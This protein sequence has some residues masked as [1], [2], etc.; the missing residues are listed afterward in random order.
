MRS[1]PYTKVLCGFCLLL[2][3]GLVACGGPAQEE[4]Q[5]GLRDP[6]SASHTTEDGRSVYWELYTIGYAPGM[7]IDVPVR[8]GSAEA[9]WQ[10]RLCLFLLR[11]D[12]ENVLL[13]SRAFDVPAGAEFGWTM[14]ARIPEDLQPTT[15]ALSLVTADGRSR[16]VMRVAIGAPKVDT[17]VEYGPLPDCPYD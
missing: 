10:D 2:V 8:V 4:E 11:T 1:I 9:D 15:Y 6:V 7:E 16:Q 3:V 5:I 17:S 12:G 13:D 14:R